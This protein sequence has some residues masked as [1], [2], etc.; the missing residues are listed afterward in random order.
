MVKKELLEI[1]TI[2]MKN[3]VKLNKGAAAYLMQNT[4]PYYEVVLEIEK[5]ATDKNGGISF[6]EKTKEPVLVKEKLE[7]VT[8]LQVFWKPPK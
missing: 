3:G 1:I 5:M 8:K 4:I 7:F 2:D 6:D